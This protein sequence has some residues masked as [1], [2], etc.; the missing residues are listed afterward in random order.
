MNEFDT[1]NEGEVLLD[2]EQQVDELENK[3]PFDEIDQETLALAMALKKAK[4]DPQT[5]ALF[6]E[7]VGGG[8][9][10]APAAQQNM[11]V[12]SPEEEQLEKVRAEIATIEERLRSIPP[13]SDEATHLMSRM[14]MLK[15]DEAR[16]EPVVRVAKELEPMRASQVQN[17]IW[18]LA[19]MANNRIAS[20]P[21]LRDKPDAQAIA[22]QK[23]DEGLRK[24]AQTAPDQLLT[25][26]VHDFIEAIVRSVAYDAMVPSAPYD[27]AV[28]TPT[29]NQ[30]PD[31]PRD[32]LEMAKRRGID[33]E[34]I[35]RY[36][37]RFGGGVNGA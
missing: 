13:D 2:S 14:A 27:Q 32:V 26:Q 17:A 33:P 12:K 37:Q 34:D 21:V 18:Q 29:H 20:D 31:I 10:P 7:V 3:S 11:T 25:P 22:R 4:E 24:L 36:A 15:L 30:K 28:N 9:T 19:Q 5:A 6:R 23:V 1:I 8:G 16:L 35:L